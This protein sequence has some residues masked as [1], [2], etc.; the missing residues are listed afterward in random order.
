VDVRADKTQNWGTQ[1]IWNMSRHAVETYIKCM[2]PKG[3]LLKKDD[4]G[5]WRG[6]LDLFENG[7]DADSAGDWDAIDNPV[8]IFEWDNPDMYRGKNGDDKY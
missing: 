1:K 7:I 8:E 5:Y 3:K 2:W 4:P 6:V